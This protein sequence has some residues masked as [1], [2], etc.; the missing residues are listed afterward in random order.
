L[1]VCAGYN[2]IVRIPPPL[3]AASLALLGCAGDIQSKQAVR[4][5]ILNHLSQ[6]SGL[7]LDLGA[8]EVEVTAVT[9]R[10]DEADASIAFRPRGQTGSAA[11]QMR[12]TLER[13]GNGW[14]VKGKSE[15]GAPHGGGSQSSAPSEFPPGHP[16]VQPGAPTGAK[17]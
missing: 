10:A 14:V 8:M 7:D 6:R 16:P 2:L 3:L 15:S 5:G 17:P 12:Y 13:K 11:M 4:E 9:F 1:P